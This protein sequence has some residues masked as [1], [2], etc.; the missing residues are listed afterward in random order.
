MTH[1]REQHT[2][3]QD[4]EP[5][6]EDRPDLK[7]PRGNQDVEEVDVERGQDKIERV[8]GQ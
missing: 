5:R 1:D 4:V 6:E 8:L 3:K 7:G 2:E